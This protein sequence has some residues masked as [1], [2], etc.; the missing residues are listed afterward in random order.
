MNTNNFGLLRNSANFLKTLS[1]ETIQTVYCL[2]EVVT[3]FVIEI[4]SNT[5]E[6]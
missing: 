5:F 1:H 4:V 3:N 6:M 2:T